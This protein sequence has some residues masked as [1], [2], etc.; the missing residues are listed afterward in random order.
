MATVIGVMVYATASVLAAL[1]RIFLMCRRFLYASLAAPS[2]GCLS[3]WCPCITYGKNK[4]R[5]DHLNTQG[6]PDPERG[7]GCC[8]ADCI[9]HGLLTSVGYSFIMQVSPPILH[10]TL[11]VDTG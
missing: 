8:N 1:V 5:Y 11:I 2:P 4:R 6:S 7:G 10:F 3:C 9:I